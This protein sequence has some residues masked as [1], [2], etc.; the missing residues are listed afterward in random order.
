M[1]TLKNTLALFRFKILQEL[2]IP[3]VS[4]GR[5]TDSAA[6]AWIDVDNETAFSDMA[7]HFIALGH[8]RIA[9]ILSLIHI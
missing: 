9:H 4:H 2:K 3:F 6:A 7:A 8:R 1:Y 5:S